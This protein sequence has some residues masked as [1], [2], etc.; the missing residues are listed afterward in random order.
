MKFANPFD[1]PLNWFID[2]NRNGG[3]L[4]TPEE[5]LT[6]T[7]IRD[8][9][10]PVKLN[11]LSE[12]VLFFLFYNCTG[13]VYQLAAACELYVFSSLMF[14]LHSS[15]TSS[16]LRTYKS[17]ED[18]EIFYHLIYCLGVLI[19]SRMVQLALWKWNSC[20]RR[21]QATF[22]DRMPSHEGNFQRP[23]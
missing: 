15:C 1:T 20:Y 22:L 7:H 19:E 21:E 17:A 4:Q 12:D 23:K 14:Q 10:P 6:N 16:Q 11:K 13:E 9:L 8:K 3:K 18:Q 2:L 5:Y